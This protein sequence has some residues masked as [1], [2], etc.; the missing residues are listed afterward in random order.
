MCSCLSPSICSGLGSSSG[1]GRCSSSG[2]CLCGGLSFGIRSS[3]CWCLG[4]C[5]S[6]SYSYGRGVGY[7]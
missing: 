5:S 6:S 3:L 2:S 4:G 1:L 7:R